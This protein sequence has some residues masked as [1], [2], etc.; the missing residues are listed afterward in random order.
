MSSDFPRAFESIELIPP[1]ID[2]FGSGGGKQLAATLTQQTGTD[3]PLLGQVPL[4]VSLRR[5]GDDGSPIVLSQ[6]DS[7]AAIVL[8][9]IASSLAAKPDSLAGKRLPLSV[10]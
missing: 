2:L 4:D 6:P 5:A 8:R 10:A 1:N 3:V 7:P 9:D